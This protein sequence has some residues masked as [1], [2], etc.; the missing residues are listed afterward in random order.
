M[1]RDEIMFSKFIDRV[2]ANFALSLIAVA[3]VGWVIGEVPD[4]EG[5]MSLAGI[6]ISYAG[7]AQL[8]LF[9]FVITVT[10]KVLMRLTQKILLLWYIVLQMIMAYC[11]TILFIIVFRWFPIEMGGAWISFTATFILIT[12]LM[13]LVM[14]ITTK[15]GDK[16]Y[17]KKL[18][19][20]KAKH[21]DGGNIDDSNA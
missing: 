10:S 8:F 6:G 7:L 1:G 12:A 4:T 17:Q 18:S 3:V 11:L 20:Y 21:N 5:I 14:I 19:E 13:V 2:L 15:L 9:A 16:K